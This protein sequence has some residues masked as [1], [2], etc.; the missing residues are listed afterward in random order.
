MNM[1]VSQR[2][3]ESARNAASDDIGLHES[4]SVFE[5][6]GDD[7]FANGMSRGPWSPDAQHGGAPCGLVTH[8][9][10]CH[11]GEGWQLSRLTVDLLRPVPLGY[12]QAR[13]E[14]MEGRSIARA[15]VSLYADD[16]EAVRATVMLQRT[17]CIQ[18]APDITAPEPVP[19][20]GPDA[21]SEAMRFS[22]AKQGTLPQYHGTAIASRVARGDRS[23]PGPLAAWMKLKV[24]F[25]DGVAN[26]PAVRVAAV[27]DFGSGL[28]WV[29]PFDQFLFSNADVS[30]SLLR[31][32]VGEW[33]G[34]D[35]VSR[36]AA[37]GTGSAVS[38]LYDEKGYIGTCMQNLVVRER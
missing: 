29:L 3:E 2:P 19:F 18:L 35:A 22:S 9:A 7:W 36:F 24:P 32:P 37:C 31:A 28:S 25:V 11:F 23:Q 6:R 10:E 17:G 4:A 16:R 13:V 38:A 5:R 30:I 14:T 8:L 1:A 21:C 27:A 34:V 15:L 12:L 33:V 20:P 26:S